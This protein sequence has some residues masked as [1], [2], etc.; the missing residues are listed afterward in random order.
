LF[1][2]PA[3]HLFL[4]PAILFLFLGPAIQALLAFEHGCQSK[5]ETKKKSLAGVYAHLY[6]GSGRPALTSHFTL[7]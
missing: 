1:L 6:N 7:Q 4:C 3:I 5:K 2:C